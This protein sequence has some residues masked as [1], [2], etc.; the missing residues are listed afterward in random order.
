MTASWFLGLIREFFFAIDKIVYNFIPKVYDLL[1]TIARTS[2]ISQ[3]EIAKIADRIYGFIAVFMIF[4]VTLSLITY[5]LNPDDFSDKSKGVSKLTTNVII[6]LCLLIL[7]P[8]IFNYAYQFQTMILEDNSLALL[9]FGD[10]K[11]GFF[12]TA[13]EDMA[14]MTISAFFSPD[15]SLKGLEECSNMTN[16]DQNDEVVFNQSCSGLDNNLD[17]ISPSI[18]LYAKTQE[19]GS[20][21]SETALKNYVTGVESRSL[22][23]LLR[24]EIINVKSDGKY[25]M[26]YQMLISTAV[27]IVV[28][29]LLINFC[30]DIAL[31]SIKLAFYQLVAPIPILSYVDPKSG[32]DGLFKK[33]YEASFK[34]FLSL[35]IRL[36]AVYFAVYII[37]LV[38][39]LH[40]VDVIT[41]RY[42]NGFLIKIF[43]IIGALMFAK[44]L[45]KILEGLGIKLDGNG[46]FFLNPLKKFEEE[47]LGGK[48]ITG[49]ARGALVGTAGAL[50][51]AGIGRGLSGAWRGMTSG[52]GWSETGKAEAEMNRKM[53]QAKLDGSTFAGRMGARLAAATGIMSSSEQIARKK[54]AI[55]VKN[56]QHDNRIKSIE[57][58]IAPTKTKIAQQKAFQDSVSKMENRAKDEIKNGNSWIGAEYKKRNSISEQFSNNIGQRASYTWQQRDIDYAEYRINKAQ[59]ELTIATEKGDAAAMARAQESLSEAQTRKQKA[60]TYKGQSTSFVIDENDAA[61][62]SSMAEDW[63]NDEGMKQYMTDATSGIIDDA[64]FRNYR[65]DAEKAAKDIGI[66]L[67]SDGDEI[68]KQFG[69][70]KGESGKLS[71]EIHDKEQEIENIKLEK[72]KLGDDLRDIQ[73]REEKAKANENVIK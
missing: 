58:E 61:W 24:H 69:Q 54:H 43:I 52:K 10:E 25:I 40:F 12:S 56:K 49:A 1:I 23:L 66:N 51:G 27:G 62:T 70:S 72:A 39:D 16:K 13:G 33:W 32:K 14:Y 48:R 28:V 11:K 53:R 21:L 36:L 63:L 17:P 19:D 9:V 20:E 15:S 34:T 8:Y 29:L 60:E 67:K 3:T 7:T 41:G 44:Q 55:E 26:D 64:S 31:R 22:G 5:V 50:T 47:A 42:Q 38:A 18:G 4:K 45:P 65:E 6:S 59:K 68:H 46:K 57:D 37:S 35:F 30:M 71:R 73:L 2:P